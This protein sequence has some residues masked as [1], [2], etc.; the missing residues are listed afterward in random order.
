MEQI[1]MEM[2]TNLSTESNPS[3]SLTETKV[4]ELMTAGRSYR[5]LSTEKRIPRSTS[6]TY[7]PTHHFTMQTDHLDSEETVAE[8]SY[9]QRPT[10]M[11]TQTIRQSITLAMQ[12]ITSRNSW[13]EQRRKEERRESKRYQRNR[14]YFQ[15]RM[16][17]Y[18]N[19][20]A[21][22]IQHKQRNK[23]LQQL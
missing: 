3:I 17:N 12:T 19:I 21:A 9:R 7:P 20:C 13:T 16:V 1:I 10:K 14:N 22:E 23:Y 18:Q 5:P 15:N 8:R 11:Y 6:Q 2:K 4:S